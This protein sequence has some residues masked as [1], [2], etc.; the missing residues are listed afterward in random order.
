MTMPV[1]GVSRAPEPEWITVTVASMPFRMSKSA[2][3]F[4]TIML[5]PSTATLAPERL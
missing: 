2:M 3:G 1:A 5:R 4:P